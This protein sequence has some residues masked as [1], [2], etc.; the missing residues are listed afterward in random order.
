M[1]E[2]PYEEEGPFEEEGWCGFSD[3]CRSR[4]AAGLL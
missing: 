4:S 2:G 1:E 3:L